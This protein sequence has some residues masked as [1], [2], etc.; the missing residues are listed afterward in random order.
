SHRRRSPVSM[1]PRSLTAP[2]LLSACLVLFFGF[3]LAPL[4]QPGLEYDETIF[5]NAALGDIDGTFVEWSIPFFGR[6][7]PVMLMTYVGALKS[8]L[9]AP[10]FAVA[11][12]GAAAI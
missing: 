6:R 7:L 1:T 10:V 9:Y 5:V 2:V 8:W 3:A 4:E 11:G 12:T